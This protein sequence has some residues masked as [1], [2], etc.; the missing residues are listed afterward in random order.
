V[1]PSCLKVALLVHNTRCKMSGSSTVSSGNQLQNSRR[2]LLPPS[3]N[4]SPR[5]TRKGPNFSSRSTLK[6]A[7]CYATQTLPAAGLLFAETNSSLHSAHCVCRPQRVLV[8]WMH[9]TYH[10]KHIF[11]VLPPIW[12]QTL[13]FPRCS[14]STSIKNLVHEMHIGILHQQIVPPRVAALQSEFRWAASEC[15]MSYVLTLW[16]LRKE[17]RN[18]VF[19][20][21]LWI[22]VQVS[23]SYQKVF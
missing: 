7:C 9:T 4:P 10:N 18:G 13:I 8:I 20:K 11:V 5:Y 2:S 14:S 15:N 19:L 6:E 17:F 22:E 12:I 21:R 23:S 1:I 16:R 3:C